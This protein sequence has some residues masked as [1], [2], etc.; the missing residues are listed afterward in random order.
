MKSYAVLPEGYREIL[1]IDLQKDKKR[2]GIVNGIAAG[3][4]IVMLAA[5]VVFVPLSTLYDEGVWRK[6]AAL[7]AGVVVYLLAHEAVHG[8]TM[9]HYCS[10]AEVSFGFTGLYAYAASKAYYCRRDYTVIGLAP[11]VVWGMILLFLNFMVPIARFYVVYLIQVCNISGAAGDLYV[12]WRFRSLPG[13]MLVQDDGV[14]M[15]VYSAG[16]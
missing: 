5:A 13:D 1:H 12:T 2:M 8:I 14:A 3:I 15:S 11:V 9:R 10:G 4:M 6:L 16:Q 7:C